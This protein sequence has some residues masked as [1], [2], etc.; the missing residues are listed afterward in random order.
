MQISA[1]VKRA[2]QTSTPYR[3]QE[4]AKKIQKRLLLSHYTKHELLKPITIT[5]KK[6]KQISADD[7]DRIPYPK[8]TGNVLDCCKQLC[9]AWLAIFEQK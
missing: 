2:V 6:L 4:F 8:I 3:T 9:I 5:D 1:L 7:V